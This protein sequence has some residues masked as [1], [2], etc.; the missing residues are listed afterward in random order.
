MRPSWL[1]GSVVLAL[2]LLSVPALADEGQPVD[3]FL[4]AD[5][6]LVASG[7]VTHGDAGQTLWIQRG[8][9]DAQ[10]VVNVSAGQVTVTSVTLEVRSAHSPG[11]LNFT[12]TAPDD[13]VER[14]T[15]V[16]ENATLS[17]EAF[18]ASAD[19][20]FY[21]TPRFPFVTAF[22]ASNGTAVAKTD[23]D[24]FRVQDGFRE[25]Y[26]PEHNSSEEFDWEYAEAG[27]L[28]QIE[29]PPGVELTGGFQG[30]IWGAD[31]T[32]A[33]ET[34]TIATYDAGAERQSRQEGV[35]RYERYT[36]LLVEA[37]NVRGEVPSEGLQTG[38]YGSAVGLDVDGT[39]QFSAAKGTLTTD[40][41]SYHVAQPQ[42]TQ[43]TGNL[44]LDLTPN[45]EAASDGL[46]VGVDGTVDD[47]TLPFR[48]SS[49]LT[50]TSTVAAAAGGA[51]VAGLAAAWYLASAKGLTF[52]AVPLVGKR[53]SR[54]KGSQA[55]PDVDVD[56]PG[57][58]L[59]DPDRFALYHLV[60]SRPG[61]SADACRE[62]AGV[63]DAADQLDLL[64]DH[65]LLEVVAEDPRRYMLPGSLDEE[66]A[67]RVSLL[68]EPGAQRVAEVLAVHGLAP[69]ERILDRIEATDTP[70]T[71][72][73]AQEL[74]E[75]LVEQSL[76]YRERGP[77]GVV[78]DS[79][80]HLHDLLDRMG[81]N[82][83]PRIS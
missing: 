48:S 79:T 26:N 10:P 28:I 37:R 8:Q 9:A 65:G 46:T 39:A 70:V 14:E 83:V 27:P 11:P 12:A 75:R 51:T 77:D 5:P 72:E 19:V 25:Y 30:Y 16:V 71:R 44:S 68:R 3:G 7:E 42:R 47:T 55:T 67:A 50:D 32:L 59:F 62:T 17:L 66:E 45:P 80:D 53:R 57:D 20:L 33:N 1:A 36:Y 21:P 54:S 56:E 35:V 60:R 74:I 6:P 63:P 24:G 23:E 73:E 15:T 41:G 78:V 34:E 4:Q 61:L 52:A 49:P 81:E 22:E 31:V 82:S 18:D 69:E 38:L 29:S 2:V 58:L 64:V 76:A 13:G 40:D 43:L